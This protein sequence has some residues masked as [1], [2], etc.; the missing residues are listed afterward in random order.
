MRY[1]KSTCQVKALSRFFLATAVAAAI[2]CGRAQV[3]TTVAGTDFSFPS[4][5]LL[6]IHAPTGTITGV[7]VASN[8]NLYLTDLENNMVFKVDQKGVLTV[9]AGNGTLGFSGDGGPA[10]RAALLRP[11]S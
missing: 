4:T 6:A 3:I 7:A 10:T 5:P 9:V 1:S 8:G 2:Y 11:V